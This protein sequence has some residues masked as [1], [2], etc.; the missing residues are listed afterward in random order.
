M[1]HGIE[2]AWH[3]L[4]TVLDEPPTIEEGLVAAGLRWQVEEKPVCWY[5]DDGTENAFDMYAVDGKKALVRSTD[6]R[7]LGVV[8]SN[9]EVLQNQDAFKFFDPI[10][11]SNEATLEAAGSLHGGRKVWVLARING[12]IGE[13]G[14]DDL[15]QH[16]LLLHNS[17]DGTQSLGI[18]YSPIRVVCQNTLTLAEG[19]ARRG[20]VNALKIRHTSGMPAALKA[21]QSSLDVQ[22]QRF[23]FS[24]EAYRAIKAK[25]LPVDGLENY[26]TEVL[27]PKTKKKP[28]AFSKIEEFYEEAPGQDLPGVKG[29]YWGAYNAVTY[30]VTHSRGRT[31]DARLDDAWFG[32]AQATNQQ[33]LKIA[34]EA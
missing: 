25:A 16:Y 22:R 9:Y 13:V 28:K 32:R 34:L 10:L 30:W 6:K 24:M 27:A 7:L 15:V 14:N 11:Q 3:K 33:A 29:T 23:E 4:G 12:S 5:P 17:H 19:L 26:V 21:V 18:Q 2:P 1:A 31:A 20:K 8:G